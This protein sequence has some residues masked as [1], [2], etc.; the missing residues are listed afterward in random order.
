[1]STAITDTIGVDPAITAAAL[2]AFTPAARRY[3]DDQ[4]RGCQQHLVDSLLSGK[5]CTWTLIDSSSAAVAPG[6]LLQPGTGNTLARLTEPARPGMPFYAVAV[7]L[8]SGLPNT[9]ARVAYAGR[10]EAITIGTLAEGYAIADTSTGRIVS[11][12]TPTEDDCFVGVIDAA[13]TLW[14]DLPG[15]GVAPMAF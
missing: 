5:V 6:D 3:I 10:V 12:S 13:G 14:L 8:T 4:I 2:A 9:R 7:A 11:T 1:M 15:K